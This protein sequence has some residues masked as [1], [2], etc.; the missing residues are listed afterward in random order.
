MSR[1]R[2][3]SSRRIPATGTRR[4]G[5]AR[6]ARLGWR[7]P[8]HAQAW[9]PRRGGPAGH[10]GGDLGQRR[11]G[12]AAASG[13]PGQARARK[14]PAKR[15]STCSPVSPKSASA[16]RCAGRP[17]PRRS[18]SH[19]RA[20]GVRGGAAQRQPEVR[21][22]RLD[23]AERVCHEIVVV[24]VAEPGRVVPG[25]R[26][27]EACPGR[28]PKSPAGPGRSPRRGTSL[29]SPPTPAPPGCT[30]TRSRSGGPRCVWITSASGY[31]RSRASSANRWLGFF[32]TQRRPR[33]GRPIS[34]RLR[35][36]LR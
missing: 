23:G 20:H 1:A 5:S 3:D 14:Y 32:S 25:A 11:L 28:G 36:C 8:V 9:P 6:S 22:D 35:R 7:S 18:A 16:Y 17:R 19:E 15:S 26:R 24:D 33:S 4:S 21:V 10:S 34:C 30:P 29:T 12:L 2:R 27:G 31:T 13:P